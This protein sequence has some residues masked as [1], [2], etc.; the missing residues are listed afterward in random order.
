MS[1][2]ERDVRE[3]DD[4]E[5]SRAVVVIESTEQLNSADDDAIVAMMTGQA[6]EEYVYS[7][8][9][10]GKNVEGLTLAGIN[11]AANRR[12]GIQVDD[13]TF[14]EREH[15]W[16]AVVKATD[17]F[18]N[19]SRYGAYEQPKRSGG[20]EDPFAFTKAIHKAQ[21]NAVKQLIPT[22]VIKEVLN[23]YL[24]RTKPS[25]AVADAKT[26][27]TVS[28]DD[29]VEKSDEITNQQ[30]AA[31]SLAQKLRE[32]L[33][34][35]NVSQS[36]FWNYVRRRF[37][38][39]SRNEMTEEHWTRLAAE[40]RAASEDA[41]VFG[42]FV[43]RIEQVMNAARTTEVPAE[44]APEEQ[45]GPPTEL[46]VGERPRQETTDAGAKRTNKRRPVPATARAT[47]QATPARGDTPDKLF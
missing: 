26:E 45:K 15:S 19:S 47:K 20:R 27:M 9:Q 32:S 1:A 25:A 23:F 41:S 12:G 34:K 18:T 38:V 14:E 13:V 11:E 10:G 21:R 16:I 17:T 42:D 2:E 8:R 36:D 46:K 30:R 24:R 39:E 5:A 44:S 6:I 29:A 4:D 7:F 31:F 33:E 28:V 43:K 22:P 35:R 37:H 40:L 3:R